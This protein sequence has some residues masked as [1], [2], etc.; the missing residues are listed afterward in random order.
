MLCQTDAYAKN[1]CSISRETNGLYHQ[2]QNVN[3][4]AT[5][6]SHET[7]VRSIVAPGLMNIPL[8]IH[9]MMAKGI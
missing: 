1:S 8:R 9:Q 3:C 6:V 2:C 4:G 5:F 7:V